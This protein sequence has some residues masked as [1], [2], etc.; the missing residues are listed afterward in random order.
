MEIRE[1]QDMINGYIERQLGY[2]KNEQAQA[3]KLFLG[4]SE[5]SFISLCRRYP[6]RYDIAVRE[7]VIAIK[8][9]KQE[10]IDL[11]KGLVAYL[12][13]KMPEK[14]K[15]DWPPVDIS[16]RVD[17]VIYIMK[18]F[19]TEPEKEQ[20]LRGTTIAETLADELWVSTRTIEGDLSSIQNRNGNNT[21][22]FLDRSLAINGLKRLNGSIRFLSS[23]HPIF[24]MEN[25]TGVVVM[26]HA[27]LEKAKQPEWKGWAMAAAGHTWNQLT[28]Y[29]KERVE[30][31]T[32][33][34]YADDSAVL[35]LFEELKN[36]PAEGRF[37][38][39]LEMTKD[40]IGNLIG[41]C[42]KAR[43]TCICSYT[44][45]RGAIAETTGQPYITGPDGSLLHMC[46]P[47]GTEKTIPVS[48]V[49]YCEISED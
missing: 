38:T 47:D 43:V 29:A 16:N 11:Y 41:Y 3:R 19:Q 48:K 8:R 28:D 25:L 17:R 27:L 10:A 24:L 35:R 5:T 42:K 37:I 1:L 26:I 21:I 6:D 9:S 40:N 34:L 12:N 31:A 15:V 2:N 18:R 33:D 7:S 46:R 20:R 23:V 49:R 44:D 22:S 39:E 14:I 32:C 4:E 36:M 13:G 30:K 45:E